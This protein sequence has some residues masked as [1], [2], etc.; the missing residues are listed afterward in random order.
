ME[1][2]TFITSRERESRCCAWT[3]N[4]SNVKRS[5]TRATVVRLNN[6]VGWPF[7]IWRSSFRGF[8]LLVA[9]LSCHHCHFDREC[10]IIRGVSNVRG[11][12]LDEMMMMMMMMIDVLRPLL[13]RWQAKW[14][15]RPP[16]VMK[17]SQRWN[18]LQICP[19]RDSNSGGRDLWSMGLPTRP[20]RRPIDR[21]REWMR[22]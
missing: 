12:W 5:I 18:T 21:V 20:W 14:T 10:Y 15:E 1:K 11:C 6:C 19:R 8:T 13:C 7:L 17:Q 2:T 22:R 4:S 9:H 16:K 3:W